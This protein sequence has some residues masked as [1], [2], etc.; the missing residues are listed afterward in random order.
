MED[1]ARQTISGF[2]GS[3]G[4]SYELETQLLF[5]AEFRYVPVELMQDT[6]SVLAE[7]GRVLAGLIRSI[8]GH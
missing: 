3:R 7:R 6:Q 2:I 4:C 5:A 8:E 1:R